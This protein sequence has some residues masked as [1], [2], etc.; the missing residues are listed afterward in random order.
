MVVLRGSSV[1]GEIVKDTLKGSGVA[2]GQDVPNGFT[3]LGSNKRKQI[4][5]FVLGLYL[6]NRTLTLGSPDALQAWDES[7]TV[8]VTGPQFNGFIKVCG[9]FNGLGQGFF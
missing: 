4:E 7:D 3:G 5:P 6:D 2:L 1:F 8:F 9:I